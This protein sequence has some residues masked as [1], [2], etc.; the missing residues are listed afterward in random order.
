MTM[1]ATMHIDGGSRGNPGPAAFAA[2]ICR[3]NHP[4][5]EHAAAM[6]TATNNIAEYTALVEGLNK[7]TELG[8][9][10]LEVFS[11]SELLVKQM[12]GEYKVKNA[13]LRDLYLEARELSKAFT[14]VTFQHIRRELNKRADELCNIAMDGAAQLKKA[15]Q[16]AKQQQQ[17][18]AATVT[19]EPVREDAITCLHAAAQA[20]ARSGNATTPSA[21]Q[22][23]DQLW[24]LLE[25]QNLLRKK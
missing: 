15:Q 4:T 13:D 6:G 5:V 19:D 7:A 25:E 18:R 14:M 2:V 22:V 3:Q 20:W 1:R 9:P 23:W 11:D 12:N 8:I 24:F 17:H 10:E 16:P 21:A